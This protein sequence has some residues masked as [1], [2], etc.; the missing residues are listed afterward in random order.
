MGAEALV[1]VA[2][3]QV[4]VDRVEPLA[5]CGLRVLGDVDGQGDRDAGLDGRPEGPAA[6]TALDRAM[7]PGPLRRL[8]GL[9][10]GPDEGAEAALRGHAHVGGPV[11]GP[12]QRRV[13]PALGTRDEL[14]DGQAVGV[15]LAEERRLGEEPGD[16]FDEPVGLLLHA[17]PGDA[18]GPELDRGA[19]VGEGDGAPAARQRVERGDRRGEPDGVLDRGVREDGPEPQAEPARAGGDRA[20]EGLGRAAVVALLLQVV[21][22]DPRAVEAEGLRPDGRVDERADPPAVGGGGPGPRVR[23]LE[24]EREPH[25]GRR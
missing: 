25:P 4:Q 13:R 9:E 7:L 3:V 17:G 2:Q 19:R 18:E 6:G 14:P 23:R 10:Q 15:V 22:G 5:Q 8:V 1:V 21:L 16:A 24:Q 12:P 11:A 20:E